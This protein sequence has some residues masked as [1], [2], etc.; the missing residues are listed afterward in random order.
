MRE[1]LPRGIGHGVPS[2]L[3]GYKAPYPPPTVALATSFPSIVPV[4]SQTVPLPHRL[5]R[6]PRFRAPYSLAAVPPLGPFNHLF[7][8][9]THHIPATDG[10]HDG[11]PEP[12]RSAPIYRRDTISPRSAPSLLNSDLP[13]ITPNLPPNLHL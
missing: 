3:D 12:F 1:P 9:L 7:L 10:D 5:A 2:P 11:V 4:N 13:L 6:W 8:R